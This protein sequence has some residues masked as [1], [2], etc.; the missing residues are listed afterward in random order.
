MNISQ[1]S[2]AGHSGMNSMSRLIPQGF[3]GVEIRAAG[4]PFN[5]LYFQI[6]EA[7]SDKPHSVGASVVILED[8]VQ[9]QTRFGKFSITAIHKCIFTTYNRGTT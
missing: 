4:R 3:S 2:C 8:R 6:L 5:P 1:C 9:P 7:V